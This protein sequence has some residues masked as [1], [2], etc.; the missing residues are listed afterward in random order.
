MTTYSATTAVGSTTVHCVLDIDAALAHAHLRERDANRL[1]DGSG[2]DI[3]RAGGRLKPH[4]SQG[5]P[6]SLTSSYLALCD[7]APGGENARR[8]ESSAARIST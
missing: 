7:D 6:G 8:P 1:G 3:A 2:V 4:A 5:Q